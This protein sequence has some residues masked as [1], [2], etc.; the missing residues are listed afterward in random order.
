[1]GTETEETPVWLVLLA[2]MFWPTVCWIC[3]YF[4]REEREY[5]CWRRE[6]RPTGK[7][8]RLHAGRWERY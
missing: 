4:S 3:N 7:G 8:L 5:R 2:L 1:M 6:A